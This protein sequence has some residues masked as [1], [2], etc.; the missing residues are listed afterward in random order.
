MSTGAEKDKGDGVSLSYDFSVVD[1][2]DL[3]DDGHRTNLLPVLDFFIRSQ[4]ALHH[5]D[6]HGNQA[7]LADN[8]QR[9]GNTFRGIVVYSKTN[10]PIAYSVYYPMV[11]GRGERGNYIE[12]AYVTESFRNNG[13]ME[14]VFHELATRCVDEGAQFLQWSTDK[15]NLP[16]HRFSNKMGAFQSGVVTLDLTEILNKKYEP[17]SNLKAAWENTKFVS[18]PIVGQHVNK[19]KA[20]GITPDIIRKTGDIDFKGFITFRADNMT[21]P[22]AVTPGWPHMSTF[23]QRHGLYLEQTTFSLNENLSDD[24]KKSIILSSARAA[25]DYAE[26]HD[27]SYFKWHVQNDETIQ[28]KVIKDELGFDV[29]TMV[30]SSDSEMLVYTLTNGKLVALSKEDGRKVLLIPTDAPIGSRPIPTELRVA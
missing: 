30:A 20:L 28:I 12:D 19:M 23:K 27:Y 5:A 24:D 10:L 4:A 17:T 1:L 13:V 3:T 2:H 7:S 18:I 21:C 25:K 9:R 11:N 14:S 22:V 6:Y 15:R 16:F 26:Q 8:L 29:D